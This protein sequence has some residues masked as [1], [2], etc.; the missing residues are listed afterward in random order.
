MENLELLISCII[1]SFSFFIIG[2][3]LLS[4]KEKLSIKNIIITLSLSAVIMI[5]NLLSNTMIDN[6]MKLLI[7][8]MCYIIY[9]K[10]VFQENLSKV[11]LI[12]FLMYLIVIFSETIIDLGLTLI[13]YLI[14]NNI[15]AEIQHTI[16]INLSVAT[17]SIII[18]NLGKEKISN[19]VQE[20]SMSKKILIPISVLIILALATLLYKT[21]LKEFKLDLN[22]IVTILLLSIF[23]LIGFIIIKQQR[24]V[25]L[26][27][28][29]Y[30]KLAE[31][32][33]VTEGVLEDYRLN[34]HE[35]KNQLII[36]QNMI[37]PKCKE[38]KEYVDNLVKT[39]KKNKYYFINELKYIPIP[40]LKGFINFKLM[41]MSNEKLNLEVLINRSL[42]K[43]KLK[44]LKTK[45]KGDFYSILGVFLDNAKEAAKESRKKEVAFQMDYTEEEIE[46]VVGNTYKGKIDLTKIEE[47]GY[48]SKG[49]NRGTGLHLVNTVLERN[50]I[51]TKRTEIKNG[52]FIQTLIINFKNYK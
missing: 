2:N 4:R 26:K 46:V 41:E 48:S 14:G 39:E 6:I 35:S 44:N 52:Y 43:S 29:E 17:V 37:P 7:I 1:M 19:L 23:C 49:Q 28:E 9:Y 13:L 16:G 33:K 36:I 38:L 30:K 8:Y 11:V 32:S 45:D 31:Y 24:D 34:L 12:S 18:T 40:E 50:K 3:L 15:F 21:P 42:E 25:T 27:E 51:F 22:F 47:Y 5:I 10:L 20:T